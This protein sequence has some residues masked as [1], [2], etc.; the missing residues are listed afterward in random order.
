MGKQVWHGGFCEI[1][2]KCDLSTDDVSLYNHTNK[3]SPQTDRTDQ[4]GLIVFY[5]SLK[6]H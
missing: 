6:A 3:A 1:I 2:L 4:Y 5:R